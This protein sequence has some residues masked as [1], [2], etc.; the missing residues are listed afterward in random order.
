MPLLGYVVCRCCFL[1][2]SLYFILVCWPLTAIGVIDISF[3]PA[4][5]AFVRLVLVFI[6]VCCCLLRVVCCVPCIS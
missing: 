2:S 3:V 5:P 1:S 4:V 6:A